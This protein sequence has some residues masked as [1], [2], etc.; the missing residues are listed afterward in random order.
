MHDIVHVSAHRLCST[1]GS[2]PECVFK[3]IYMEFYSNGY[4]VI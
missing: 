4:T 1:L 2:V 3:D